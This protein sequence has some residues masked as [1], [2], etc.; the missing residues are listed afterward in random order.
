MNDHRQDARIVRAQQDGERLITRIVWLVVFALASALLFTAGPAHAQDSWTGD[1]K[2]L[3]FI[4][5]M[6]IGV[7]AGA[8]WPDSKL[9][10]W[11][12]AMVPGLIKEGIDSQEPGNKFSGKDVV[13]NGLGAAVGVHLP[14]LMARLGAQDNGQP[15]FRLTGRSITIGGHWAIRRKCGVTVIAYQTEF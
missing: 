10:A 12:I 13:V 15:M 14:G 3:H 11:G 6:A 7:A 4:S 2:K 9:K 8:A 5:S 1:D